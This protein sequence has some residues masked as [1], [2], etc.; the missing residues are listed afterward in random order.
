[1]ALELDFLFCIS[2]GNKAE[3]KCLVRTDR[4]GAQP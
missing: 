4:V 2:T 3:V 1:V